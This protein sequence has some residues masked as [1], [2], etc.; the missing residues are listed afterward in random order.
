[1]S[2][3]PLDAVLILDLSSA[4]AAPLGVPLPAEHGPRVIEVEPPGGDRGRT[5]EGARC[6]SR[7]RRSVVLDLGDEEDRRHRRRPAATADVVV[8]SFRPGVA[9]RLGLGRFGTR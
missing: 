3:G 1:M 5:D 8:E 6:W 9:G 7:S 4:V 2:G